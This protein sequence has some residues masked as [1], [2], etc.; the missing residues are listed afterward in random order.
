MGRRKGRRF[1]WGKYHEY[2]LEGRGDQFVFLT[3]WGVS[4]TFW[5]RVGALVCVGE[6]GFP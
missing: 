4:S 2:D 5:G 3:D 6:F 1:S